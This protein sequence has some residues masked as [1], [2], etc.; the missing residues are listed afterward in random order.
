MP[1]KKKKPTSQKGLFF[2]FSLLTAECNKRQRKKRQ[3]R[4]FVG[5]GGGGYVVGR[6]NLFLICFPFFGSFSI[7]ISLRHVLNAKERHTRQSKQT[8]K[9]MRSCDWTVPPPLF[10]G[11][12]FCSDWWLNLN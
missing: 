9:D 4:I 5:G 2:F 12:Y 8:E 11:W 7:P 6:H 1:E 10:S 3:R